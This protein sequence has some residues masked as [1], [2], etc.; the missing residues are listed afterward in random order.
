MPTPIV[1]SYAYTPVTIIVNVEAFFVDRWS[2][3]AKRK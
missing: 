2:R 1:D 3:A